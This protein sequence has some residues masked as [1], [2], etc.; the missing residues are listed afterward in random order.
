MSRAGWL[1]L[2]ASI[3][4]AFGGL[5]AWQREPSATS[6][7]VTLDGAAL[8]QA[9]GCATCHDGPDSSAPI[10]AGFPSLADASAWAGDRRPNLSAVEYLSESI[11]E[12]WAFMSP[13]FSP[14][15]S[16]PTNAM[17]ALELSEAEVSAIVEYLLAG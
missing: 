2:A 17:P 5:V 13:E 16:G 6:A 12:P 10:G 4:A 8:L 9:K 15:N 7:M 14:G 3:L 11:R 1:F